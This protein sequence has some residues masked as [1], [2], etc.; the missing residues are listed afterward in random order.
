MKAKPGDLTSA[1]ALRLHNE[2]LEVTRRDHTISCYA[3]LH[4]QSRT[5]TYDVKRLVAFSG[6]RLPRTLS[7]IPPLKRKAFKTEHYRKPIALC[8]ENV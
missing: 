7:L 5:N 8:S 1:T 4:I 3:D 6:Y 2:L